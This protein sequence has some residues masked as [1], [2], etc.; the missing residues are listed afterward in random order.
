[1]GDVGEVGEVARAPGAADPKSLEDAVFAVSEGRRFGGYYRMHRAGFPVAI[2]GISSNVLAVVCAGGVPL[3]EEHWYDSVA[4]SD[5]ERGSNEGSLGAMNI[6][7]A[8]VRR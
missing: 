5:K 7:Y 1:M 2:S 3:S 4:S 8:L 6:W